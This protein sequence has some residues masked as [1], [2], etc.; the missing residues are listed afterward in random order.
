MLRET[1]EVRN[2]PA[3]DIGRRVS[4][5]RW[6]TTQR[7]T[8][9]CGFTGWRTAEL[10]GSEPPGKYSHAFTEPAKARILWAGSCSECPG[11]CWPREW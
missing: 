4:G 7:P 9:R 10:P 1:G 3:L 8:Q 5:L 2:P 6:S 11:S